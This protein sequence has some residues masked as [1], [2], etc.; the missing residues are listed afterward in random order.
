MIQ[1]TRERFHVQNKSNKSN[2][3]AAAS[4]WIVLDKIEFGN[5]FSI[6]IHMWKWLIID[7][8]N[9]FGRRL[10]YVRK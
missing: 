9:W 6:Y 2:T 3:V 10:F 8:V 4:W 5:L 1:S 7:W